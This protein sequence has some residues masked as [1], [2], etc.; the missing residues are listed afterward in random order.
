[1]SS[2]FELI[3][4]EFCRA[5][6][7]EMRKQ[8]LIPVADDEMLQAHRDGGDADPGD[9]SSDWDDAA[10]TKRASTIK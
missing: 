10:A 9:R 2:I 7:A 4:R 3:Y 1:M 5:R 8:L 6:L